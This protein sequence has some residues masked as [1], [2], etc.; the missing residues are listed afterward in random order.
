MNTIGYSK[1]YETTIIEGHSPGP[2]IGVWSILLDPMVAGTA[3][4]ITAQ[5]QG[6][7]INI[8]DVIYGDVWLC[9]GQSNMQFTAIQ[10]SKFT[11]EHI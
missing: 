7:E 2:G 4:N 10:V 5:S 11:V 9:S 8:T 1:Y 3:V 6:I